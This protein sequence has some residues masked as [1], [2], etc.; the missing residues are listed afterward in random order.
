MVDAATDAKDI[1]I[2]VAAY[3]KAKLLLECCPIVKLDN[4]GTTPPDEDPALY[5]LVIKNLRDGGI[6]TRELV[7]LIVK[8]SADFASFSLVEAQ[9]NCYS[10][11]IGFRLISHVLAAA[12]N[13]PT[14]IALHKVMPYL[15]NSR[16]MLPP[17]QMLDLMR[18]SCDRED[19]GRL[20]RCVDE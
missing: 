20:F 9:H 12:K 14:T 7:Q 13:I 15:A 6:T 1:M 19:K 8:Q 18:L 3:Q 16:F 4:G 2:H 11:Y 17:E 10:A 5:Y